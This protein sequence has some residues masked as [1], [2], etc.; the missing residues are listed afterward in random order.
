VIISL[1]NTYQLIFAMQTH[2]VFF[3]V[4]TSFLNI[5]HIIF[6]LQRDKGSLF[7]V[8]LIMLSVA[9]TIVQRRII[10]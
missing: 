3:E 1:N 9:Q 8:Y 10:G 4:R 7:V 2:C 5:I 6:L